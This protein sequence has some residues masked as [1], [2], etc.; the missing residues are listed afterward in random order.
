MLQVFGY[1]LFFYTNTYDFFLIK[2]KQAL[3]LL[4]AHQQIADI[5]PDISY[6]SL[7]VANICPKD[8]TICHN[9]LKISD[10][11]YLYSQFAYIA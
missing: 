2:L 1:E 9:C 11:R 8:T 3:K 7:E 6:I 5:C 4:T 10:R